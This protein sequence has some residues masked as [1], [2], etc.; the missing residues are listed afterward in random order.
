MKEYLHLQR[1]S[2]LDPSVSLCIKSVIPILFPPAMDP[3][4][5][6]RLFIKWFKVKIPCTDRLS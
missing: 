3:N 6:F 1:K 5:L 2:I 4:R